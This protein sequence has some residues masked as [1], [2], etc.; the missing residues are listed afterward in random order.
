MGRQKSLYL[1]RGEVSGSTD[2]RSSL[3]KSVCYGIQG[4]DAI[5]AFGLLILVGL[6]GL[7]FYSKYALV[8]YFLIGMGVIGELFMLMESNQSYRIK[9]R[10]RVIELAGVKGKEK[11][12]DLGTGRGLLAIGFAKK[13]CECYGLDIWSGSDLWNNNLKKAQKNAEMEN[14]E[15]KFLTGDVKSIPLKDINFDLVI[16]SSMIH[17][18]HSTSKMRKILAEIKRVL[19]E[20]GKMIL[21]DN[22]PFWG[23]GWFK[24]R[25]QKELEMIGFKDIDFSRFKLFTIITAQS[26][27]Q[28][29][30]DENSSG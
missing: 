20:N 18:I 19:K 26:W 16:S 13:G 14:V 3:K 24:K 23:P 27:N 21:T 25:W 22:N 8:F 12:L 30:I 11:V 10:D 2:R 17:N 4:P 5:I 28:G 1:S 9:L 7:L 15:V 29:K 6:S